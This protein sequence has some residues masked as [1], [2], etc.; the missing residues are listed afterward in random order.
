MSED[1]LKIE[2]LKVYADKKEIVKGITLSIKPGQTHVIM[3]QNGSGK[4]T[5]LN[6]LAGHPKYKAEGIAFFDGKD[7]LKMKPYERARAGLF[8]AFQ[9]PNEIPGV[10]LSSLLRRA[11]AARHGQEIAVADFEKLLYEKMELLG[12]DK[13]MAERGVNEGFS[14]GE[15]KRCEILQLALLNPKLA[16][17]DELDSGLDIDA[18]SKVA[19]ALEKAKS[20]DTSLVIVTHYARMLKNIKPDAVHIMREGKIILSGSFELACKLEEKGYSWI[21]SSI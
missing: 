14:G 4:S 9:T 10:S 2:N 11:Y 19:F 17:L 13:A 7:L 1:L 5:L 16:L 20:P 12:M 18:L 8:L 21:N 3:G 6:A 15:K